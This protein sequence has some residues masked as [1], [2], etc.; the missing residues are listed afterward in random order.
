[1][2]KIFC[3][4]IGIAKT[5]CNS[6]A[7]FPSVKFWAGRKTKTDSLMNKIA[8]AFVQGCVMEVVRSILQNQNGTGR[9]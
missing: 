9:L 8:F 5:L 2:L 3:R 6:E 1:M 4:F 7:L